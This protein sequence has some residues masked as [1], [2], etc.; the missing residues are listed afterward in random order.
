MR[1]VVTKAK[2]RRGVITISIT[3]PVAWVAQLDERARELGLSR[4]T[5]CRAVL[6]P[7]LAKIGTGVGMTLSTQELIKERQNQ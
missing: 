5:F 3:V 1:V 2:T 7:E 6:Q 4:S